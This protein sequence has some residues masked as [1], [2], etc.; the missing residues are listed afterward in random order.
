MEREIR[1]HI[2]WRVARG[3]FAA[4][5]P[6]SAADAQIEARAAVWARRVVAVSRLLRGLLAARHHL[7]ERDGTVLPNG[8]D[9]AHFASGRLAV[10]GGVPERPRPE[11]VHFAGLE[12]A[13]S[14]GR[15]SMPVMWRFTKR[16]D[17]R[18]RIKSVAKET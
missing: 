16:D 3:G 4:A 7:D 18:V 14:V 1:S 13:S 17:W 10:E 15:R 9:T 2:P 12:E 8:V 11:L 6:P 5:E